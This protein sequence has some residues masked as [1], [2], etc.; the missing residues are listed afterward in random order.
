MNVILNSE[1]DLSWDSIE[2][3]YVN[4]IVFKGEWKHQFDK[5]KT[6]PGYFYTNSQ[7]KVN[8]PMMTAEGHFRTITL[9]NFVMYGDALKVLVIILYHK[10]DNMA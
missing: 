4:T 5:S 10:F 8:V 9:D 3:I 7:R 1:I 2:L 6:R